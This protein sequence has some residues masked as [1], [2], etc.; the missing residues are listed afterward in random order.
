MG[1]NITSVLV[2]IVKNEGDRVKNEA[3]RTITTLTLHNDFA[4]NF[5]SGQ[6]SFDRVTCKNEEGTLKNSRVAMTFSP[7]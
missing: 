7:L 4:A 5:V 6:N 3:S 2:N 1:D